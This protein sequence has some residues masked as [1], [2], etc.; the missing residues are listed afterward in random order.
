MVFMYEFLNTYF[1]YII[2]AISLLSVFLV[3]ILKKVK[4]KIDA[5]KLKIRDLQS[6][7]N[8]L[9]P[10]GYEYDMEQD[11]FYSIID[12]WQREMGYTR[13]FDESAA[14]MSMI[15]DCEP[16]YFEYDNRLWMIEFLKGQYGMTSGCEVGVYY[17]EG[18]NL[19][20]DYF[21]WTFY[22]CADD[23]NLLDM[24]FTLK[25]DDK[26]MMVRDEKHWWLT[27]FKLGEFSNPDELTAYIG[28]K[29]KD[30]NMR[31]A[32]V[33]GME[34]A[35]YDRNDL[36]IT[37]NIVQFK[38]DEPKT[39]QPFSRIDELDEITQKKNKVLCD[40]YNELTAGYN[41]S[42]DKI[43]ALQDIAPELMENIVFLG[44]SKS[45]FEII[46]RD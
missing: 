29:L 28:V 43:I 21:K 18:P 4:S 37:N 42:L 31:D 6:L 10:Y 12:A 34:E 44:K 46:G 38:F 45:L 40:K 3:L 35:G 14:P 36:L 39:P 20:T 22:E 15:I 33:N 23:D 9:R 2:F 24:R 16:I 32:F 26:L 30:E 17:T 27:G 5:E 19:D 8:F 7:N 13:L 41:N 1:S 25:K 11:I